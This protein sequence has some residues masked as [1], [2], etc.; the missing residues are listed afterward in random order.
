MARG[1]WPVMMVSGW[2]AVTS[3]TGMRYPLYVLTAS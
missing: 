2:E 1:I 3:F